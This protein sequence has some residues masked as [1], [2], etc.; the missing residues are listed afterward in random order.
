MKKRNC[1][2]FIT[3]LIALGAAA[4]LGCAQTDARV[5]PAGQA[6]ER[7]PMTVEDVVTLA[8]AGVSEQ[9]ILTQIRAKHAS[10]I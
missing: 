3:F 1:S 6:K 4:C 10:L 9:V 7:S 8:K 5:S 2:N